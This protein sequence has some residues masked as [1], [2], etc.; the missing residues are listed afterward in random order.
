[1][2][3]K[4]RSKEIV[5]QFEYPNGKRQVSSRKR[6]KTVCSILVGGINSRDED[7]DM[8]AQ[9][10]IC[11]DSRDQENLVLAR[12]VA[13]SRALVAATQLTEDEKQAIW[14]GAPLRN[15]PDEFRAG[16]SYMAMAGAYAR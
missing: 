13:F 1:M 12:H 4:I 7:K 11:R 5:V 10:T 15:L 6:V 3:T 14:S 2:R 8:V 9:V 16:M